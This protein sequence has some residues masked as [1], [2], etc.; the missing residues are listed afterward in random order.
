MIKV[1]IKS[2]DEY[3]DTFEIEV[4]PFDMLGR[5]CSD[6]HKVKSLIPA[7]MLPYVAPDLCAQTEDL[8][9]GVVG[10]DFFM[11]LPETL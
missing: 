8:P 6:E 1:S 7:I 10:Q 4:H 3:F 9:Y 5:P 2:Y 11:Q